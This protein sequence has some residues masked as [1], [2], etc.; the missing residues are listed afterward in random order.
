M[1]GLLRS[2][3]SISAKPPNADHSSNP[4][5]RANNKIRYALFEVDLLCYYSDPLENSSL[6]DWSELE[7]LSLF[8]YLQIS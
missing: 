2:L 7:N 5:L 4:I 1:F 8:S 3:S 6:I